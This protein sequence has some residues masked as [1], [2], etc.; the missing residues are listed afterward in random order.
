[1]L[2]NITQS[3]LKM[4]VYREQ[5][6]CF[7]WWSAGETSTWL[8]VSLNLWR[9]RTIVVC[10]PFG[11]VT[12]RWLTYLTNNRNQISRL[13]WNSKAWFI[14]CEYLQNWEINLTKYAILGPE[15]LIL[16]L[17]NWDS[18]SWK[19]AFFIF[20]FLFFS[21]AFVVINMLPD[22]KSVV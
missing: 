7:I 19:A 5:G 17:Q 20:F 6:R 11:H 16:S 3:S 2:A 4:D 21:P 8:N 9:Y 13:S 12:R 14:Q 15:R 22:R 1:M 18:L 10:D